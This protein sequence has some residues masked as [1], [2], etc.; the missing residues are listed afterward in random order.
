[1]L[2]LRKSDLMLRLRDGQATASSPLGAPFCERQPPQKLSPVDRHWDLRFATDEGKREP[3]HVNIPLAWRFRAR[4]DVPRLERAA[5]EVVNRHSILRC[6]LDYSADG[7][8]F[9][10]DSAPELRVQQIAN[11]DLLHQLAW[12][13]FSWADEGPFRLAA[14]PLSATEHAVAVISHHSFV[15]GYAARIISHELAVLY[16]ASSGLQPVPLQF[17]DYLVSLEKWSNEPRADAYLAHWREYLRG[18]QGLGSSRRQD[19]RICPCPLPAGTSDA[20][21]ELVRVERVGM[22][23]VWEA[24]HHL[25]LRQLLGRTDLTT[26]SVD[27]GRRQP[28]LVSVVGRFMNLLPVRS[29]VPDDVTFRQLLREMS[30][31][32]RKSLPYFA[33]PHWLIA[34]RCPF[35]YT[36]DTGAL[37]FVPPEFLP[38]ESLGERLPLPPPPQLEAGLAFPL[39]YVIVVSGNTEFYVGVNGDIEKPFSVEELASTFG[40]VL[41]AAVSEPDAPVSSLQR[42]H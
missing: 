15:D 5:R 13:P 34:E 22:S 4:L 41:A 37:N 24:A 33:A 8:R 3:V 18:A 7:R 38:L 29:S 26:L 25:T 23:F 9:K 32:R 2:D 36:G 30:A 39:P 31:A 17:M 14:V 42:L 12:K 11:I 6:T 1:M 16:G 27:V 21:R 40:P 35:D 28:E 19:A 20:I 10:A